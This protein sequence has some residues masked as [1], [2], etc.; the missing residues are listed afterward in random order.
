MSTFGKSWEGSLEYV[1]IL[2]GSLPFPNKSW[3]PSNDCSHS[4]AIWIEPRHDANSPFVSRDS[5]DRRTRFPSC[6]ECTAIGKTH[7]TATLQ[8]SVDSIDKRVTPMRDQLQWNRHEFAAKRVDGRGITNGFGVQN[9]RG[10]ILTKVE[11]I[12]ANFSTPSGVVRV[13]TRTRFPCVVYAVRSPNA[14]RDR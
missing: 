14:S 4:S 6:R 13:V 3:P 12:D 1:C 11:S 7:E 8:L 10:A 2:R 9:K 5:L